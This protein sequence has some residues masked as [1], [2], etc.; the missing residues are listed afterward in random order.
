MALTEFF[1]VA[2]P[3][4]DA[5]SAAHEKGITHR[6]LKPSNVM[7]DEEGRAKILDFGLAKSG[8][9]SRRRGR[10]SFLPRP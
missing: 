9:P 8:S 1:D 7:I 6:D 5:L 4:A 3:L 10:A 2:V